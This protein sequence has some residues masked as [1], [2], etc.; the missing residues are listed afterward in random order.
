MKIQV[1]GIDYLLAWYQILTHRGSLDGNWYKFTFSSKTEDDRMHLATTAT[2]L[3]SIYKKYNFHLSHKIDKLE[4]LNLPKIDFGDI[5]TK[6]S[7][8]KSYEFN[9]KGI[10]KQIKK[11][12]TYDKVANQ[13]MSLASD[14][15]NDIRD[16]TIGGDDPNKFFVKIEKNFTGTEYFKVQVPTACYR[17]LVFTYIGLKD[18]L[19][20][21]KNGFD[22][23]LQTVDYYD[24][25]HWLCFSMIKKDFDLSIKEISANELDTFIHDD[26]LVD[27]N[28]SS[29]GSGNSLK[30]YDL[31]LFQ[32]LRLIFKN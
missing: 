7:D 29:D 12:I 16:R 22:S 3:L 17:N 8:G 10:F 25:N 2:I 4:A 31:S 13:T 26:V 6:T 18:T 15:L 1:P 20:A 19:T 30:F 27:D 11:F 28:A 24:A 14:F 5:V 9:F 32:F 21:F 23:G